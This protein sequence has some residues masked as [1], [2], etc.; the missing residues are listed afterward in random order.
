MIKERLI[1]LIEEIPEPDVEEILYYLEHV[2]NKQALSFNNVAKVGEMNIESWD[3]DIYDE[4][5]EE[6]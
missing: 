2:K 5:I 3:H 4:V 1:K 6:V